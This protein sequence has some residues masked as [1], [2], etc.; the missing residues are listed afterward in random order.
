MTAAV[1][2]LQV[3]LVLLELPGWP[4][5]FRHGLGLPCPGCGLSRSLGEFASGNW[6]QAMEIHAFAPVAA[7]IAALV[8]GASFMPM[9]SR[10]SLGHRIERFEQRTGAAMLLAGMFLVYWLVRAIF[11]PDQLHDLVH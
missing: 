11:F 10:R 6:R 9:A 3:A 7:A 4:C 2:V 5:P 8:V 1:L